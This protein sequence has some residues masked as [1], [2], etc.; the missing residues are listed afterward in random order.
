MIL[1]SHESAA[2]IYPGWPVMLGM[3]DMTI[4]YGEQ[5][6]WA[7]TKDDEEINYFHTYL[8]CGSTKWYEGEGGYTYNAMMIDECGDGGQGVTVSLSKDSLKEQSLS[9]SW[10]ATITLND[11]YGICSSCSFTIKWDDDK[12]YWETM[13]VTTGSNNLVATCDTTSYASQVTCTSG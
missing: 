10:D 9:T 4:A 13:T 7:F 11:D 2:D 12:F 3:S 1:L 8:V 6:S 5:S